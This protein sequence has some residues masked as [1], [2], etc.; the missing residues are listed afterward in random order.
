MG[1]IEEYLLKIGFVYDGPRSTLVEGEKTLERYMFMSEVNR[2]FK[3][4]KYTHSLMR[5]P[6]SGRT[7]I[8]FYSKGNVFNGFTNSVDDIKTIFKLLKK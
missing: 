4:Q 5:S 1:E 8:W 7:M 2:S 3:G 6:E